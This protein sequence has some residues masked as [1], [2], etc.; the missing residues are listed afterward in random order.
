MK[1]NLIKTD[2]IKVRYTFNNELKACELFQELK[3]ANEAVALTNNDN[4]WVIEQFE[5][6][7]Y[8]VKGFV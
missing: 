1:L 8:T 4:E 6:Q 2:T 3:D 5:S 7:L